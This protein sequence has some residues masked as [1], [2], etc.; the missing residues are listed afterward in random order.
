MAL[1]KLLLPSKLN[2]TI[3][4]QLSQKCFYFVF[5]SVTTVRYFIVSTMENAIYAANDEV[6]PLFASIARSVCEVC[7]K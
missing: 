6:M 5:V 4:E 3:L 1:K 2:E 7:F